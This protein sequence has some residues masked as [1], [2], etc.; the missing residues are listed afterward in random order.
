MPPPGNRTIAAG[1]SPGDAPAPDFTD[2]HVD[3]YHLGACVGRTPEK[4]GGQQ[5]HRG[6]HGTAG[7]VT[8][9]AAHRIG[10]PSGRAVTVTVSDDSGWLAEGTDENCPDP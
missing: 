8:A 2:G 4:P 5:R 1:A 3:G 6:A 10:H 9:A 7:P